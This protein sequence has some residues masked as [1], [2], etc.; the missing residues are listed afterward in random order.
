MNNIFAGFAR[1]NT[2]QMNV[3]QSLIYRKLSSA[4]VRYFGKMTHGKRA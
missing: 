3:H 1:F 2:S 4:L